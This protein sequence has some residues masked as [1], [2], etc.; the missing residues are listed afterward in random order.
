MCTVVMIYGSYTLRT[1]AIY[2]GP[3]VSM[4]TTMRIYK[5]LKTMALSSFISF[6]GERIKHLGHSLTITYTCTSIQSVTKLMVNISL[7]RSASEVLSDGLK[8]QVSGVASS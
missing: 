3:V 7:I 1:T 4:D 8:F 6:V 2:H 5:P